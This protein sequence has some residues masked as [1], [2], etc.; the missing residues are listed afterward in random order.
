MTGFRTAT[1]WTP[2][3]YLVEY[4]GAPRKPPCHVYRT[5]RDET[6]RSGSVFHVKGDIQKAMQCEVKAGRKPEE[7]LRLRPGHLL[8]GWTQRGLGLRPR[9]LRW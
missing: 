4:L 2:P 1:R 9:H 7:S 5:G 3:V 6:K 8:V